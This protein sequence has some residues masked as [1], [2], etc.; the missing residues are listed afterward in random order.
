MGGNFYYH[1]I[2]RRTCA[3]FGTLFNNVYIRHQ[4]G[5]GEDFSYIKVPIRY[6]PI[7]QFLARI[8]E[9]PEFRNRVAVTLPRMAFQ[10]GKLSY[11]SSRKSSTLQR[12]NTTVGPNHTPTQVYMPVP[13]NLPIELN[14]ATKYNDD[15]FQI[16][17][18]I[19]PLFRPEFNLTVN[20]S[21]TLGEKKDIPLVLQDISPF[22]DNFEGNFEDRRFITATLTFIAKLYFFGPIDADGNG[23]II[24]KVQV[25]YYSDTNKVNASRERRYVVTPRATKDY[26]N[27]NT[28]TISQNI[29]SKVTEFTVSDAVNLEVD[30]Y[31]QIN[32]E[33]MRITSISGNT[34]TVIRG[35]NNTT[36]Q[37]HE[38][39]DS[40]DV[41]D[42][43]DNELIV[44]GD[45]FEFDEERF[46]FGDGLIYSPRLG[47]DV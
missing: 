31:I 13:Y 47:G 36:P 16:V 40:I 11:D 1:E 28:T 35:E 3:A 45:D 23:N 20:L 43:L 12:F 29:T 17:E 10:I 27:D 5:E 34:L 4:D 46:D 30:E 9:K 33:S 37:N 8:E 18:Q 14:I 6:A 41:I 25:D 42:S 7:Q 44:P 39:G 24:K 2:I 32:N 26:N 22:Q 15:M 21:S 19:L 38:E